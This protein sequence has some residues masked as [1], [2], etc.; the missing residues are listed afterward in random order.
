MKQGGGNKIK[1]LQN[2]KQTIQKKNTSY[3]KKKKRETLSNKK[4]HAVSSF[5]SIR[6]G[7]RVCIHRN[8]HNH[9]I[10]IHHIRVWGSNHRSIRRS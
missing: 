1:K 2:Y 3:Q 7:V 6:G 4:Y 8:L 9:H 10:R 5:S